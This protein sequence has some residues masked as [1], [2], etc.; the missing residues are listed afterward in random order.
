MHS[1]WGAGFGRN[2][3][4]SW[5]SIPLAVAAL[6]LSFMAY[7]KDDWE[8]Y[9]GPSQLEHKVTWEAQA[10]E[11]KKQA[12]AIEHISALCHGEALVREHQ[13]GVNRFDPL[14]YDINLKLCMK[15]RQWEK[16]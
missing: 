13:Q 5:V 12:Q 3:C 6:T 15:R 10:A 9:D 14:T 4:G 1:H 11:A 7:A 2:D 16:P 8:K